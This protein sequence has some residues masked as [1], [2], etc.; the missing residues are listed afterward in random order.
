MGNASVPKFIFCLSRFP[1]YR[2]SGLDRFYCINYLN[3][4]EYFVHTRSSQ[5]FRVLKLQGLCNRTWKWS[6]SNCASK[7]TVTEIVFARCNVRSEREAPCPLL[8]TFDC[9]MLR[10]SSSVDIHVV[11]YYVVI[12]TYTFALGGKNSE[13]TQRLP[14]MREGQHRCENQEAIVYKPCKWFCSVIGLYYK[15]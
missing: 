3:S 12:W 2:G 7:G 14:V 9:L 1:V 15:Q 5:W 13:L 8:S 6:G 10:D 11:E 4:V